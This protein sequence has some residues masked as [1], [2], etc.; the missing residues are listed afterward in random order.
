MSRRIL[1]LMQFYDPEPVYK[2]QRFAEEVAKLGYDVEVVTGFPNYPGGKV[3]DGFR[4]SPVLK[5]RVNNIDITRL[6][7]YPSHNSN[8]LGRALNY[9]SFACS[10]LIY[11][12]FF[13]RRADLV[14][15]YHPPLT[16][17]LAAAVAK[18][19]RRRPLVLDIHDLWPDT[20][21]A[22][23]MITNAR[24]LRLLDA[25]CKWL[26]RVSDEIIVQ[27]EGF[28]LCLR[29]RG[30]PDTKLSTIIS[31]A[32]EDVITK[33]QAPVHDALPVDGS[34]RVLFAGNMGRAQALD[35][36]V[37]AAEH[38]K[39]AGQERAVTFYLLGSGLE[40]ETLKAQAST[41][42]LTNVVF[43]PRVPPAEVGAYL[44]AADC[45]LVHLK[46][47][48][49]FAITIPSKTQVYLLA[50]KP[51][52]IA[53]RGEAAELVERAGAGVGAVPQNPTSI[54]EAAIRLAGLQPEERELMG[55]SGRDFYWRELSRA[56]G[57]TC[58]GKIFEAAQ[59]SQNIAAPTGH[60]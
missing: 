55:A 20:V 60:L 23:G 13:V 53:V 50:G 24:L 47:D 46:D 8:R 5:S 51:I 32:N 59:R 45:L 7:L 25:A 15:V 38:L 42:G 40:L 30:V 21:S 58:F 18:L 3:Y 39:A 17:G 22:S 1:L 27:S 56:K 54:A 28:Q 36:V 12:I 26:Y 2:G 57:I 49:L 16:V 43:L 9:T 14:Y 10:L 35:S 52:L 19:I 48:P 11:L 4:I 33:T 6:A 31:W 37:A 44:A 34:L 41:A 29:E